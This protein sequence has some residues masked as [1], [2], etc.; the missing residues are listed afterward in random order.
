MR[1]HNRAGVGLTAPASPAAGFE[2]GFVLPY[3]GGVVH[4]RNPLLNISLI[5]FW[6]F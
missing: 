6:H 2:I 4:F 3:G 5:S 1:A